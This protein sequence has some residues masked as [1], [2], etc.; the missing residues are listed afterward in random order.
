M[1]DLTPYEISELTG[2][3]LQDVEKLERLSAQDALTRYGYVRMERLTALYHKL[4]AAGSVVV[5]TTPVALPTS[6]SVFTFTAALTSVEPHTE[7]GLTT[8]EVTTMYDALLA[9]DKDK[10]VAVVYDSVL[11]YTRTKSRELVDTVLS[12]LGVIANPSK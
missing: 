2:M 5:G 12:E 4:A 3:I 6:V 8:T 9:G 11:G 1:T 7:V 10:A